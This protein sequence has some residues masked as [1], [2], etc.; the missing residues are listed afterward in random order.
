MADLEDLRSAFEKTGE[1]KETGIANE[2]LQEL[3][4]KYEGTP[5]EDAIN[6]LA[7][8]LLK[9]YSELNAAYGEYYAAADAGAEDA[10]S[11][12]KVADKLNNEFVDK[13]DTAGKEVERLGDQFGR[14]DQMTMIRIQELKDG[15]SQQVSLTSTMIKSD[16]EAKSAII[17]NMKG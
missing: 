7:G 15:I 1:K 10:H 11:K 8:P 9:D 13:L 2:K 5:Y 4:A 6:Q 3:V 14:D 12:K 17:M 16:D